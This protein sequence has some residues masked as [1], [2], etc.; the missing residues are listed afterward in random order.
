MQRD[1]MTDMGPIE[2]TKG[3]GPLNPK[4]RI[5]RRSIGG[6]QA[7][8]T[9]LRRGVAAFGLQLLFHL[10]LQSLIRLRWVQTP[11]KLPRAEAGGVISSASRID[12][13]RNR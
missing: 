6:R 11:K 12:S 13:K 4:A 3:R 2:P 8:I 5:L 9:G 7:T 10:G 1:A